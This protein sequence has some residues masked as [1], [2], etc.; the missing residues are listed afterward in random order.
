MLQHLINNDFDFKLT[1]QD[2]HNLFLNS[3]YCNNVYL[4][5]MMRK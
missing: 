1:S 4:T 5:G 3:I 2:M